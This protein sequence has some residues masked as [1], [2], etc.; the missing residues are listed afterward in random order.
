[1]PFGMRRWVVPLDMPSYRADPQTLTIERTLQAFKYQWLVLRTN[2]Y[3]HL[4]LNLWQVLN[5]LMSAPGPT[6]STTT[7]D[8]RVKPWEGVPT[9]LALTIALQTVLCA[10]F[11]H[12]KVIQAIGKPA[13]AAEPGSAE[14]EPLPC[15]AEGVVLARAARPVSSHRHTGRA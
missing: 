9:H 7:N 5:W 10:H 4:P 3:L 13:G 14:D 15:P 2:T 12:A 1:M 8:D 6:P 11:A